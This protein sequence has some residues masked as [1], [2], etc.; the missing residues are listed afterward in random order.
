LTPLRTFTGTGSSSLNNE[1]LKAESL[2]E[3]GHYRE[4]AARYG[5]AALIAPANPLPLI[6]R[7]HA[8]LAAGDYRS[9]AL[10]L[11]RGMERFP[12][13]ARFNIDLTALMGSGEIIDIRRADILERLERRE[14]AE[15]RFL[16]GYLEY[17]TGDR[18]R[19][20]ANL[21]RAASD[22]RASMVIAQYPD[23]L[24]KNAPTLPRGS[25]PGGPDD[26]GEFDEF[27]GGQHKPEDTLV[28]PPPA[29]RRE[30][31]PDRE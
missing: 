14:T 4:A 26:S 31:E 13:I 5:V 11:I 15:L 28:I 19:G 29:P 6:G 1:M 23:L 3:I 18:E 10:A 17:H 21:E 16:L 22:P 30:P 25:T 8:F 2:M 20:M 27:P 9:A 12:D 7:G 24:R